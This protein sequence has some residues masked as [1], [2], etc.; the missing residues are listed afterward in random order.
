MVTR[1]KMSLGIR[2]GL[3]PIAAGTLAGL[4][5]GQTICKHRSG[6]IRYVSFSCTANRLQAPPV[7][8][9]KADRKQFGIPQKP[10]HAA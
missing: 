5:P 7:A 1:M 4:A 2:L 3:L 6:D 8:W 10:R 9:G